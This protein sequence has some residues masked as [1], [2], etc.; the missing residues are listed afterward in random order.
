VKYLLSLRFSRSKKELLAGLTLAI[1]LFSSLYFSLDLLYRKIV[2]LIASATLLAVSCLSYITAELSIIIPGLPAQAESEWYYLSDLCHKSAQYSLSQFFDPKESSPKESLSSWKR[3]QEDLS[4]IQPTSHETKEL[5]EFLKNQWLSKANGLYSAEWLWIAP[6][7]HIHP[8]IHPRTT[9]CYARDPSKQA[10]QT[11]HQCLNQWKTK[12]H[13]PKHFPLILTRPSSI[14]SYLPSYFSLENLN[15]IES[16]L[17]TNQRPIIDC[18]NRLHSASKNRKQWLQEWQLIEKTLHPL[19]HMHP[20][21]IEQLFDKAIGGIR[22]LPRSNQSESQID[23]QYQFL[24]QW[25]SQFGLSATLPEL[26]RH[27]STS[28]SMTQHLSSNR[29]QISDPK[30]LIP[31]LDHL[32][33]SEEKK[34]PHQEMLFTAIVSMIKGCIESVD[35][36]KIKNCQARS[37]LVLLSISKIQELLISYKQQKPPFFP[38]FEELNNHLSSLLSVVSPFTHQDFQRAYLNHARFIPDHFSHLC[39][40][41]LH[42]SGM[43]SFGG[44]LK[45]IHQISQTPRILYGDNIYFESLGCL[46]QTT[47]AIPFSEASLNDFTSADLIIAQFNSSLK[48]DFKTINCYQIENISEIIQKANKRESQK[49]FTVAIDTTLDSMNSPKIHNLLSEFSDMIKDGMINFIFYKSGLKFDL[50]GLD[51]CAIAPFLIIQNNDKKWAPFKDLCEDPCLITDLQSINWTTLAYKTASTQLQEYRD[52]I[53]KRTLELLQKIPK[54][55]F[56]SDM[57][58]RVVPF[59][60]T[61]D[62][63]FID[64]RISGPFHEQRASLLAAGSL[65][66]HCMEGNCPMFFR[67]SFGFYH[68]NLGFLAGDNHSIIR[69]T[70]GIDPGQID[71]FTRCFELIDSLNDNSYKKRNPLSQFLQRIGE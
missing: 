20:I 34:I 68:P 59:D 11:Y 21:Y 30:N 10:S 50:F 48:R 62:L 40:S 35:W 46:N 9:N 53:S 65:Y 13:H 3:N 45:A 39:F 61:T 14:Q 64:I 15:T 67:R 26:N 47:H 22:I 1:C 54:R 38:F 12:L 70:L 27:L 23:E 58:Y 57:P 19:D 42:A 63:S 28:F 60:E 25:I 6:C 56:E 52:L 71:L 33:Q 16:T 41:S 51:H 29:K 37:E 4:K 36:N 18:T 2:Y 66:L 55:M 69:L 44:I 24:L 32:L 7:F 17:E 8:Q 43:T 5:I 31:F 49:P